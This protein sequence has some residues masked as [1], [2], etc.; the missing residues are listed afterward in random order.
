MPR[1]LPRP[2]VRAAPPLTALACAVAAFG[3]VGAVDPGVP[4]RYP[5]CPVPVLTGLY[6]PGCGGLRSAHAVAHGD[7]VTALEANALA[8]AGYAVG[9]VLLAGWLLRALRPR[10]GPRRARLPGRRGRRWAAGAVCGA[11][12]V[13]TVARNLPFG[14]VPMP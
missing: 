8:V 10:P 2:L 14:V 3:Y 5:A 13:F 1:R 9:G 6:C 4:G 11:L 12:V 7:L